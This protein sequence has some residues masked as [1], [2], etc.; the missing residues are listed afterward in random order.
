MRDRPKTTYRTPFQCSPSL[1]AFKG[2][3]KLHLILIVTIRRK[4]IEFRVPRQL[5]RKHRVCGASKRHE[6]IN[7]TKRK[8]EI[9]IAVVTTVM[10]T[11]SCCTICIIL[12]PRR[13]V[14]GHDRADCNG[15]QFFPYNLKHEGPL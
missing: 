11:A 5:K 12:R 6:E 15:A 14:S 4:K 13:R 10:Q 1:R 7:Y 9:D 3:T 2:A 8:T